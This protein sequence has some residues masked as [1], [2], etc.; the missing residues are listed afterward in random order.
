MVVDKTSLPPKSIRLL[1]RLGNYFMWARSL[2]NRNTQGAFDA[3]TTSSDA[4]KD[5]ENVF[6]DFSTPFS[7]GMSFAKGRQMNIGT[8]VIG[9]FALCR[10][11]YIARFI[12][13]IIANTFQRVLRRRAISN[14]G[15]KLLERRETKLNAAS[16]IIRIGLVI[17]VIASTFGSFVNGIFRSVRSA[18]CQQARFSQFS[19]ETSARSGFVVHQEHTLRSDAVTTR[20]QAMPHSGAARGVAARKSQ[21]K[22]SPES[23]P[24]QNF[25]EPFSFRFS[26]KYGKVVISHFAKA[27]PLVNLVR[28]VRRGLDAWRPV[29]ILA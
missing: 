9:L 26:R 28:V 11:Y 24:C 25:D 17:R 15:I 13:T 21:D 6:V 10:P 23:L 1:A 27:S 18:V 2:S 5:G 19:S 8:S 16:A 22:K 29:C 14:F 12:V 3:P 20:T 4:R 7:K